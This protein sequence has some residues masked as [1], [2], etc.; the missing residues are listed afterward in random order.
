M[1]HPVNIKPS[2]SINFWWVRIKISETL[3]TNPVQMALKKAIVATDGEN[4]SILLTDIRMNVKQSNN[5][6]IC[7]SLPLKQK[8]K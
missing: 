7:I 1:P 2:F 4:L 3:W 6:S 5:S 8:L